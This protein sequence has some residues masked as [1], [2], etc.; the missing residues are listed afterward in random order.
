MARERV[1]L[2]AA[3]A[4]LEPK[5]SQSQI[6]KTAGMGLYRYWQIENGEG[7]S[8]SDDEMNAVAAALGVKRSDIAWPSDQVKS[9]APKKA[10]A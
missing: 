2:R 5:R 3:R 10:V 6:A 1:R 9:K 7:Q 4:A 8:P